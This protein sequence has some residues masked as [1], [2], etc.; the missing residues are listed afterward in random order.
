MTE[1][2]KAVLSLRLSIFKN[3]HAEKQTIEE[4]KSITGSLV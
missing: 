1:K 2:Y 4:N 3:L